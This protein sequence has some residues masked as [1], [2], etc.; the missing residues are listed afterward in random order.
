MPSDHVH[1]EMT[2][3]ALSLG[4][5]RFLAD[6][7]LRSV[8]VEYVDEPDKASDRE[9][10]VEEQCIYEG[11]VISPEKCRELKQRLDELRRG[12]E[13]CVEL[14]SPSH[15]ECRKLGEEIRGVEAKLK[16]KR[17]PSL[18]YSRHH[19]GLNDLAYRYYFTNAVRCYTLGFRDEAMKHLARALHYVQDAPLARKLVGKSPIDGIEVESDEDYH[20]VFEKEISKIWRYH[21]E[22]LANQLRASAKQLDL[23][24]NEK[25]SEYELTKPVDN[26]VEMLRRALQATYLALKKFERIVDELMRNREKLHRLYR[27]LKSVR[28]ASLAILLTGLLAPPLLQMFASLGTDTAMR[29][30]VYTVAAGLVGWVLSSMLIERRWV[31]LYMAGLVERPPKSITKRVAYKEKKVVAR[32][33][34][35]FRTP[36]KKI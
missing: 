1:K 31:E 3:Y 13:S 7:N 35:A 11:E 10:V 15:S 36:C 30:G 23:Y 19:G 22:E 17:K 20:D 9:K 4:E 2:E 12:Y 14:H 6:A 8:L 29:V 21:R 25:G 5:W 26:P 24:A 16:I 32:E 18:K 34:Q 27:L 28:G 33:L